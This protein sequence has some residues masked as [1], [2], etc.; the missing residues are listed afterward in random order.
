MVQRPWRPTCVFLWEQYWKCLARML[1]GS[2]RE[3]RL[4]GSWAG[5][6]NRSAG[7]DSLGC[8]WR[9]QQRES[10]CRPASSGV[11][12]L[13]ENSC[14]LLSAVHYH[15]FL[16]NLW[17]SDAC[18]W[19]VVVLILWQF[20]FS[21][22]DECSYFESVSWRKR[23]SYKGTILPVPCK[24]FHQVAAIIVSQPSVICVI[25]P[26]CVQY[27]TFR[28]ETLQ[29]WPLDLYLNEQTSN[30]QPSCWCLNRVLQVMDE[31]PVM[32]PSERGES[33]WL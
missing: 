10:P 29:P 6:W 23:V 19:Q 32:C 30:P 33:C 21:Q 5:W 2:C 13:S 14:H 1:H 17:H 27:L 25:Q 28:A 16:S 24:L 15:F 26:L 11:I 4:G 22:G 3:V 9:C 12:G 31:M 8:P 7:L 18:G 20:Q